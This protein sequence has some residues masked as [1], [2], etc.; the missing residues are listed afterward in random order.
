MERIYQLGKSPSD[1]RFHIRGVLQE[2]GTLDESRYI[3]ED[4]CDGEETFRT[5]SVVPEYLGQARLEGSLVN[6]NFK[7]SL[8]HAFAEEGIE[9]LKIPEGTNAYHE[10]TTSTRVIL[11]GFLPDHVD[12]YF[13]IISFLRIED[14]EAES[15]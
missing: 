3:N 11:P 2:D 15:E 4:L 12:Q 13:S 9:G 5:E 8:A 1:H 7:A 6:R 14:P 10:T